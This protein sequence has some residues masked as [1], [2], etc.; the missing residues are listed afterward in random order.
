MLELDPKIL[1]TWSRILKYEF[2]LHSRECNGAKNII[3]AGD[4]TISQNM[5]IF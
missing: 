4:V 1:D 2:Q 3:T 5:H